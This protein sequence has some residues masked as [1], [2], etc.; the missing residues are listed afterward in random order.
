MR[1][2]PSPWPQIISG[3]IFL[4]TMAERFLALAAV[5]FQVGLET[6]FYGPASVMSGPSFIDY[7]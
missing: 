7:T 6:D 3:G 2:K 4:F 5:R 1:S